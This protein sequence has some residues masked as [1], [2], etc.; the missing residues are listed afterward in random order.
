M[1]T[2]EQADSGDYSVQTDSTMTREQAYISG[3]VLGHHVYMGEQMA[4]YWAHVYVYGE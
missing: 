4:T 1:L 3:L 2:R